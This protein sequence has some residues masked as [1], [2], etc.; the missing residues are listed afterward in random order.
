MYLAIRLS[1]DGCV[2]G[3][4]IDTTPV[5]L[6]EDYVGTGRGDFMSH[7]LEEFPSLS[8]LAHI[9]DYRKNLFQR[10]RVS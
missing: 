9:S 2:L 3:I 6:N 1:R 7:F 4:W 10:A 8:R 5:S